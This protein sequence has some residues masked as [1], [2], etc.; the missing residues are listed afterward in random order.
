MDCVSIAHFLIRIT[1]H[2]LI[3]ITPSPTLLRNRS[4]YFSRAFSACSLV[5]CGLDSGVNSGPTYSKSNQCSTILVIANLSHV[6]GVASRD[7]SAVSVL[8]KGEDHALRC[9]HKLKHYCRFPGCKCRDC[10]PKKSSSENESRPNFA[11]RLKLR[12]REA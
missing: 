10:K 7:G 2:L 8:P 3:R 4:G 12:F 1:P 9:H 6:G 5:L 11:R